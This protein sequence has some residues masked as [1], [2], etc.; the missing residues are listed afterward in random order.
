MATKRKRRRKFAKINWSK[1]K[2]SK[3]LRHFEDV[4]RTSESVSPDGLFKIIR[5]VTKTVNEEGEP[6]TVADYYPLYLKTQVDFIDGKVSFWRP[7]HWDSNEW[8]HRSLKKAQTLVE[9]RAAY[10]DE[11]VNELYAARNRARLK[12]KVARQ[13]K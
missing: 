3:K 4:S 6:V 12:A 8:F 11:G 1:W 5:T 13:T 10:G 9:A 2:R 7:V